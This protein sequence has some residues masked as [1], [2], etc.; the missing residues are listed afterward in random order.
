MYIL[1]ALLGGL[2]VAAVVGCGSDDGANPNASKLAACA[3]GSSSNTTCSSCI[4]DKCSAAQK[5]CYGNDFNG[6][7]CQSFSSCVLKAPDPCHATECGMPTGDCATCL[8]EV[9]TCFQQNCQST[10]LSGSMG[11]GGSSGGVG[12]INSG[13]GARSGGIGGINGGTGASSSGTGATGSTGGGVCADLNACCS[14]ITQTNLRSA[15][16]DAYSASNGDESFCSMIYES[17]VDFCP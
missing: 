15:C 3:S 9:Q 5:K 2:V 17:I 7:V 14:K 10:C 16:M 6:G 1:R 8:Q 11:A 4:Q 13:T 12:G